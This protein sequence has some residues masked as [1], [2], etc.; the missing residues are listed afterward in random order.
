MSSARVN[1]QNPLPV[2]K[3]LRGALL[4][5]GH[6][7]EAFAQAHG[8]RIGTVRAVVAGRRGKRGRGKTAEIRTALSILLQ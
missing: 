6:T 2:G 4:A 1:P 8:F 5:K 7:V 3:A